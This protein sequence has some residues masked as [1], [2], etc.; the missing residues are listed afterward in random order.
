MGIT[1][2]QGNYGRRRN[3]YQVTGFW[4]TTTGLALKWRWHTGLWRTGASGRPYYPRVED[5]DGNP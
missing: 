1:S 4:R 2:R 3:D 5:K